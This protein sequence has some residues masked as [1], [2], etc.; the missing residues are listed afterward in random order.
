LGL[1]SDYPPEYLSQEKRWLS[2]KLGTSAEGK[3]VHQVTYK[4][5]EK[6]FLP[7]QVTGAFLGKLKHIIRI[8]NMADKEAVI[9]VPNYYTE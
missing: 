9:S 7:E 5:E 2:S 1:P 4:G 6:E 8:N 3:I